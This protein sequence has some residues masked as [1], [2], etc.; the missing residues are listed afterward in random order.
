MMWKTSASHPAL[1]CIWLKAAFAVP[2]NISLNCFKAT[3]N[4]KHFVLSPAISILFQTWILIPATMVSFWTHSESGVSHWRPLEGVACRLLIS[5]LN[6][7]Q[8]HE[9]L[10]LH[11]SS[12]PKAL[13]DNI[14]NFG[15]KC[16]NTHFHLLHCCS[17]YDWLGGL[18][19]KSV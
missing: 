9:S 1:P 5:F 10:K 6:V 8:A 18:S 13:G 4:S 2:D 7:F 14:Q 19:Q 12:F 17:E 3:F 15:V 11:F 16:H